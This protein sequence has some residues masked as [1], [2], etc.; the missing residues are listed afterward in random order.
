MGVME[1]CPLIMP[2]TVSKLDCTQN[3]AEEVGRH[4]SKRPMRGIEDCSK[5]P[6]PSL[7]HL[8]YVF[9]G[10]QR[11]AGHAPVGASLSLLV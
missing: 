7:S 5:G 1:C 3:Q 8:P 2:I 11:Y 10:V 6:L 4:I 9:D